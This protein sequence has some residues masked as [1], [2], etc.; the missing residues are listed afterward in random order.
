[1]IIC[2]KHFWQAHSEFSVCDNIF[3][4]SVSLIIA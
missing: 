4:F 2:N 1:L 3:E